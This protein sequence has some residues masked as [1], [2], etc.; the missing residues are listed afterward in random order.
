MAGQSH[1]GRGQ[2]LLQA[3]NNTPTGTTKAEVSRA[4]RSPMADGQ[5]ILGCYERVVFGYE[6]FLTNEGGTTQESEGQ[7]LQSRREASLSQA[8]ASPAHLASVR[9]V[10]AKE[11]IAASG[12]SDDVIRIFDL[13][14]KRDLG[15]LTGH[16]GT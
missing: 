4:T 10:C 9:C 15:V 13:N 1:G 12:G 11:D 5:G 14:S 8:F 7:P 3:C 16:E 2:R 6:L